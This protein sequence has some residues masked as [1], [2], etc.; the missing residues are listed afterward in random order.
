VDTGVPPE[1]WAATDPRPAAGEVAIVPPTVVGIAVAPGPPPTANAVDAPPASDAP[2]ELGAPPDPLRPPEPLAGS[3][4]RYAAGD[5]AA[6]CPRPSAHANS[7]VIT[8]LAV[9]NRGDTTSPLTEVCV[10]RLQEDD[11]SGYSL[12]TSIR[13]TPSELCIAAAASFNNRLHLTARLRKRLSPATSVARCARFNCTA[14]ACLACA[15][16]R[17]RVTSRGRRTRG[18]SLVALGSEV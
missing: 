4:P 15:P 6:A 18:S 12:A 2:P 10:S 8:R 7:K 1:A 16:R 3:R 13:I 11:G 17:L 9:A 14:A 5:R